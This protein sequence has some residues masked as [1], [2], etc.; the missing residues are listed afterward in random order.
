MK[1]GG[2]QKVTLV[3]YPGHVACTIFLS[4]CNFRCPFCYSKELVLKEEMDIHPSISE[5]YLFSFLEGKKGLLEGCVLCGGEPTVNGDELVDFARKIKKM[6]FMIK[7][8]T[9]GSN[10]E[11]IKKLAKEN[12]LDYVAM[13]IKAPLSKYKEAI[14]TDI[15]VDKVKDSIEFI[16]NSGI[17]YEFRTT[18]VPGIHSLEDIILVAKEIAPAKKYFLQ[19]FRGEKGTIDPRFNDVKPYGDKI[20]AE[21]GKEIS[22]YFKVFKIR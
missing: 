13:D 12:L 2:L 9:N 20:M 3:D 8:D 19:N 1:I 4:G 21:L 18:V 10:P 5:E 6:G 22:K 11:V 7:L 15:D 17:D 14:G 16:K